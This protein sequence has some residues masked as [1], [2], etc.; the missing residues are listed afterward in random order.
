MTQANAPK[1]GSNRP[2]TLS[3]ADL[4]PDPRNARR[5]TERNLT[6]IEAALSEVGAARSIV[7]DE[8][9][10]ILAG[11]ATVQAAREVGITGLRI[12]ESDGSELIA[13]RRTGL[14]PEQ[15]RKLALY[16]NRTA[17][18]AEW[19]AGVLATL[20]DELDLSALWDEDELAAILAYAN[21]P[22]VEFPA[23]DE[24]AE[25]EVKWLTCPECGHRFPA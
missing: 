20:A 10:T 19:E 21:P 23:Y 9:G 18:L 11:N 6:Q 4:A 5:H 16:D 3:L 12:I 25:D 7:V 17:E 14:S 1:P 22:E 24:S 2:A 8:D 15:K 13:V